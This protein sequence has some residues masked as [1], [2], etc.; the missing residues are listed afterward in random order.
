MGVIAPARSCGP[1]TLRCSNARQYNAELRPCCR[2]HVVA[3]VAAIAAAFDEAGITWWAD[4]GTL[5]GAVRNPMTTWADYPWLEQ[6]GRRTPGPAAGIIPHDKDADLGAPLSEWQAA[7][8]ALKW[9]ASRRRFDMR[10][11]PVNGS[12]KVR[13]SR[14]NHT[15]VDIFFWEER[16]DGMMHRRRYVPTVDRFKG[17]E[18]H[19]DALY[20]LMSVEWEGMDIPAPRDPAAFCAHR[21]GPNWTTP[22]MANHDGVPR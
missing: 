12:I 7:T 13:L 21:Y 1:R 8:N 16:P 20:P 15:N 9:M 14:F 19:R 18:F 22:I 3:M 11:R 2:G 5:L 4:Y 17:R 6:Q 10:V